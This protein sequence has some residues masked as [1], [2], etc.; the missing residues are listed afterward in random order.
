M[1]AEPGDRYCR[2]CGRSLAAAAT[3]AGLAPL[4][5]GPAAPAAAPT[6]AAG[7]ARPVAFAVG[8]AAVG[9]VVLAVGVSGFMRLREQPSPRRPAAAAAGGQ[10]PVGV[11]GA[12]P[13]AAPTVVYPT[14]SGTPIARGVVVQP[15]AGPVLGGVLAPPRPV[16]PFTP[17]RP[18]LG[19]G[20]GPASVRGVQP[21]PTPPG[22]S[23]APPPPAQPGPPGAPVTPPV[24]RAGGGEETSV[25]VRPEASGDGEVEVTVRP[26]VPTLAEAAEHLRLGYWH[27]GQGRKEEALQELAEAARLYRL[28]VDR[29]GEDGPPARRGLESAEGGLSAL[30]WR[31]GQ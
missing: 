8:I 30:R 27:N 10:L 1:G 6:A 31:A 11:S 15:A 21:L 7:P 29:G 20:L 13:A 2:E 9:I 3:A 23:A 12:A 26:V 5:A 19:N 25:D 22:P 14:P 17:S 4:A 16:V 28:L 24:P 18:Q